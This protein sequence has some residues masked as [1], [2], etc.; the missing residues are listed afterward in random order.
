VEPPLV[1]TYPELEKFL[2]A[3]EG[4]LQDVSKAR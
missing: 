1:I 2:A 4:A 3:L